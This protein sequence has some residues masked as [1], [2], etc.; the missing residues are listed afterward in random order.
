MDDEIKIRK[1]SSDVSDIVCVLMATKQQPKFH[2]HEKLGEF[3]NEFQ[4]QP[5]KLTFIFKTL[6]FSCYLYQCVTT[7]RK[8]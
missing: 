3:S 7:T 5:T 1:T 8:I 4:C 2:A 6:L